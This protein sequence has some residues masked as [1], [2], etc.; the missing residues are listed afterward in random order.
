M[1]AYPAVPVALATHD[2]APLLVIVP[3]DGVWN[4]VAPSGKEQSS[5][6]VIVAFALAGCAPV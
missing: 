6:P 3:D 4:A 1:I 2:I 5:V